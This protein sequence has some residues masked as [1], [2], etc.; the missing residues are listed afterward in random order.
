MYNFWHI[1]NEQTKFSKERQYPFGSFFCLL[2]R[3]KWTTEAFALGATWNGRERWALVINGLAFTFHIFKWGKILSIE[4][5]INIQRVLLNINTIR[6]IL[7][8]H[9]RDRNILHYFL[10]I[11]R[12]LEKQWKLSNIDLKGILIMKVTKIETNNRLLF[13]LLA[14][15]S[16]SL[17]VNRY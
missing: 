5:Q 13:L 15:A 3:C 17:F 11:W 12:K 10:C 16:P 4:A 2:R 6:L 9:L 8:L 14:R 1:L 7:R